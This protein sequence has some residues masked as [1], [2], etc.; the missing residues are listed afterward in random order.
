M[1]FIENS[2]KKIRESLD[3]PKYMVAR[4]AT[5]I[6]EGTASILAPVAGIYGLAGDGNYFGK[7]VDGLTGGIKFLYTGAKALITNEGMRDFV[8]ENTLE[9]M[10]GIGDIGDNITSNPVETV[11]AALTATGL[12][13]VGPMIT[14][15]FRSMKRKKRKLR[16][17]RSQ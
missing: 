14:R 10:S 15:S 11:L 17:V 9:A 6:A 13:K 12:Y 5:R 8:A 1:T 16:E 3:S 4:M 2:K 7:T